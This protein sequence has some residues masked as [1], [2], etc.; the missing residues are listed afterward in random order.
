MIAKEHGLT[1]SEDDFNQHLEIAKSKARKAQKTHKITANE[2]HLTEW[3]QKISAEQGPTKFLGYET[4]LAS[5]PILALSDGSQE[6]KQLTGDQG[7]LIV[8]ETPFY[9][10]G[11]G[12]IGDQG[13][14]IEGSPEE[15]RKIGRI[16][17]CQKIND[18][19]IHQVDLGGNKV[20]AGQTYS[21][22]VDPF[23]RQSSANNHSATH[24]LNAALRKTLGDHVSQAGSL[25]TPEKL[26]FDFNHTSALNEEELAQIE[27][28]VNQQISLALPVQQTI[29]SQEEAIAQ[30]AVA[31]FGEKYGDRVRVISMGQDNDLAQRPFSKELCGGT[32]V[33]NTAQ[34]RLFKIIS[35]AGVA[36]GVRRIEAITGQAAYDYLNALATDNLLTRQILNIPAPKISEFVDAAVST[37]ASRIGLAKTQESETKLKI[38]ELLDKIKFLE[39]ELQKA[40]S[41][42]VSSDDL[43]QQAQEKIW[44]GQ[45]VLALFTRV[46]IDDR[47]ALS[48]IVD[49]LRDK[50]SNLALVIIGESAPDQTKP[51]IVAVGKDLKGFHAGQTLKN[52]CE[53][54]DAKGGG[55]PDFAQGS[56]GSLDKLNVAKAHFYELFR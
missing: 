14:L 54:L 52:L 18:V 38:K 46:D 21:L 34:I 28:L 49:Q 32:H 13:F 26:R 36:A 9:A 5:T 43:I 12:Q 7:F 17:D 15:A 39:K 55:R 8:S 51:I 25:V 41:E 35:E 37:Q 10:E 4:L 45:K 48:Q 24:L 50:H 31:M 27:A 22:Q 6:V 40:K 47:K 30:G 1:V 29:Q 23:T 16:L 53:I 11:G 56:V 2:K 20:L 44:Q 3:S 33:V 19:F 42:S